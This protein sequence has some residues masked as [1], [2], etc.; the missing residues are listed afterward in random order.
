MNSYNQMAVN[1]RAKAKTAEAA[2]AACEAVKARYSIGSATL[3]D[4]QAAEQRLTNARNAA[5]SMEEQ[6]AQ[7]KAD[8]LLLLGMEPG[9]RVRS[10]PFPRR[11]WKQSPPSMWRRTGT[12][13]WAT[14]VPCSAPAT[15]RRWEPRPRTAGKSR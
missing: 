2:L 12:R 5:A 10:G 6:A 11:I 9:A 7:L 3:A 15:Q 13:P 8:L 14:T 4:V 1:A